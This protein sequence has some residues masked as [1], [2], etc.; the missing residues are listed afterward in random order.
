MATTE[1]LKSDPRM[2]ENDGNCEVE[3]MLLVYYA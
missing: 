3:N 1:S 2:T